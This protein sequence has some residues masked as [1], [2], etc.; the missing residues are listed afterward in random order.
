VLNECS[1][2]RGARAYTDCFVHYMGLQGGLK[3]AVHKLVVAQLCGCYAHV[4]VATCL[5]H[6]SVRVGSTNAFVSN[7]LITFL[8]VE[9][10]ERSLH[11]DGALDRHTNA[12][13]LHLDDDSPQ[14]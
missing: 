11:L 4:T 6:I 8:C 12:G 13:V 7:V 3:K 9:T 2:G 1:C 10:R 14:W 5:F